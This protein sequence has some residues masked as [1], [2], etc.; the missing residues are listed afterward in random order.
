MERE[1]IIQLE[2]KKQEREYF[3]KTLEEN[4]KNQALA[5]IQKEKE[6]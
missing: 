1:R 2:K 4:M 5:K 3:M 6:K